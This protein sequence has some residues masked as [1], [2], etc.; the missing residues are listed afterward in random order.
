MQFIVQKFFICELKRRNL[1]RYWIIRI[2]KEKK[3]FKKLNLENEKLFEFWKNIKIYKK[4]LHSFIL[5]PFFFVN[6]FSLLFW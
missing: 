4:V 5:L 1:P 3:T 2:N 6:K